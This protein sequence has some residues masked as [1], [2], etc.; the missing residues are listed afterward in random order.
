[1]KQPGKPLLLEKNGNGWTHPVFRR[2]LWKCQDARRSSLVMDHIYILSK[3]VTAVVV[4]SM[5]LQLP[6]IWL[7]SKYYDSEQSA[8]LKISLT[9]SNEVKSPSYPETLLKLIKR[10]WTTTLHKAPS[11]K[12]PKKMTDLGGKA[13][14]S[15]TPLI[16]VTPHVSDMDIIDLCNQTIFIQDTL[17]NI[18]VDSGWQVLCSML[19]STLLH[20]H[21]SNATTRSTSKEAWSLSGKDPCSFPG[22][23]VTRGKVSTPPNLT[24][25]VKT[26]INPGCPTNHIISSYPQ[27]LQPYDYLQPLE[28]PSMCQAADDSQKLQPS[29][30]PISY[31]AWEKCHQ[32]NPADAACEVLAPHT[33]HVW[34][35]FLQSVDFYGTCR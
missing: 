17:G 20:V 23:K 12:K 4:C 5:Y 3:T 16:T 24:A 1:M 2:V 14:A 31:S 34:N 35:I 19:C 7:K 30:R 9:S 26:W 33:L 25:I 18:Q 10:F 11:L 21:H 28:I 6:L 29:H 27:F 8:A 15:T 32:Q 13:K 22:R